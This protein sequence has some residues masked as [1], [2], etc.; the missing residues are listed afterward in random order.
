MGDTQESFL[1]SKIGPQLHCF[2]GSQSEVELQFQL[3]GDTRV[4]EAHLL[5]LGDT[6]DPQSLGR[7]I[8]AV[9]FAGGYQ[10]LARRLR[11]KFGG[12]KIY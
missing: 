1:V 9:S 11:K 10:T 12:L 7:R 6:I 5:N 4:F 2:P 8:A 3:Q